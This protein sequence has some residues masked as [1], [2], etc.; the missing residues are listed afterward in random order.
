MNE[1]AKF[2]QEIEAKIE[3]LESKDYVFPKRMRKKDYIFVG[4]VCVICL[5]C[6]IGGYYIS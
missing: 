3:E 1:E 5:A 6:I 4:V 2:Q